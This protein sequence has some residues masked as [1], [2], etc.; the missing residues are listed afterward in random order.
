MNR[1]RLDMSTIQGGIRKFGPR[2]DGWITEW[3]KKEIPR[4]A[5]LSHASE[6]IAPNSSIFNYV[7]EVNVNYCDLMNSPHP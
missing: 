6:Q 1:L 3:T 2:V 4:Q 7:N 5:E